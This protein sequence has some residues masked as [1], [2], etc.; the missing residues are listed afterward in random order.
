MVLFCPKCKI[1]ITQNNINVLKDICL[2][3]N[4]SELYCLSEILDQDD[5]EKAEQLLFYPPKGISVKK[6]IGKLIIQISTFSKSAFVLVPFSILFGGISIIGL[7]V[8]IFM[9]ENI[10]FT[11]LWLIFFGV[12]VP[13]LWKT[14]YSILGKI[15]IVFTEDKKVHVFI[16]VGKIGKKVNINWESI[17][18]IFELKS[19]DMDGGLKR[20]IYIEEEKTVKIPLEDINE[21]KSRFLLLIL[22]YYKY[23]S[24]NEIIK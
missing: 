18:K 15:R 11:I 23:K 6:E 7:L 16:G 21:E 13:L 19:H 14:V 24:I 2:C 22:K 20:E 12:S 8:A 9:N 17:K 3:Q 4:C 1:Q 10:G 5:M